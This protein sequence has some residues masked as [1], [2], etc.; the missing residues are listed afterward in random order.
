M[1]RLVVLPC[2]D[3]GP[4]VPMY[5]LTICTC[6]NSYGNRTALIFPCVLL[7]LLLLLLLMSFTRHSMKKWMTEHKIQNG[8][9]LFWR[10]NS[11]VYILRAR[12]TFMKSLLHEKR[13]DI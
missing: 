4:T 3:L 11:K 10:L 1:F 13:E 9:T 7:L 5:I 12:F 8:V 2:F 6:F